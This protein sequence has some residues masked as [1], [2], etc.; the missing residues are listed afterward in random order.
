M[1]A[2]KNANKRRAMRAAADEL[3]LASEIHR[4]RLSRSQTVQVANMRRPGGH[5]GA[6]FPDEVDKDQATYVDGM[7]QRVTITPD[8]AGQVSRFPAGRPA[9]VH[10][11]RMA[12]DSSPSVIATAPTGEESRRRRDMK[13]SDV[14]HR[15]AITPPIKLKA[16]RYPQ[17]REWAAGA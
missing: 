5:Y 16:R 17:V 4:A 14:C 13:A 9:K 7:G 3:R 8:N 1:G 2:L 6:P 10:A 12:E 11:L 15:N